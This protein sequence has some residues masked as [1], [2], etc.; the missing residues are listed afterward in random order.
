ME[1]QIIGLGS[2]VDGSP[3]YQR[4]P[5]IILAPSN[6]RDLA[7]LVEQHR[8][9]LSQ[10]LLEH[11]AVLFR[12]FDIWSSKNFGDAITAFSSQRMEYLYRSTPRTDLGDKVYTATEYPASQEIPLHNENAYQ[13]EWPL[14]I[15][16]CCLRPARSGGA[17]PIADMRKVSASIPP[18]LLDKFEK[19]RIRYVRH[20]RPHTD[21]SWQTVFQTDDRDEVKHICDAQGIDSEWLDDE[22]LRTAQ[23]CQGVAYHPTTGERILF[24]QAHLFHSS[25]MGAEVEKAL[26][27]Q[28][29]CDYLPRQSYYGDGEK[30]P[31]ADLETVRTAFNSSAII[32]KW[33]P[34]DFLL[35]DNMQVAHGRQSYSG[36]RQVLAALLDPYTPE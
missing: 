8:T 27:A 12:K 26:I 19:R 23:I 3:S 14:K 18:D 7:E 15:A 35:A 11:G 31:L 22:T 33:E 13:R 21:I 17:T 2:D 24:N 34:S 5:L 29:G 6:N 16:L 4:M 32:F 9:E 20:Y 10:K 25:S 36:K 30:I 28:F 1:L